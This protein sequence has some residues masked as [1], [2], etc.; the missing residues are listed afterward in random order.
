[1]PM[2]IPVYSTLFVEITLGARRTSRPLNYTNV[3]QAKINNMIRQSTK[4]FA[5]MFGVILMLPGSVVFAAD[6]APKQDDVSKALDYAKGPEQD[7]V[8]ISFGSRW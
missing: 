2:Q 5:F 6:D 8:Y 3:N 4:L 1:M 7:I